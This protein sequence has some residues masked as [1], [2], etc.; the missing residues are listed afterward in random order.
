M[1]VVRLSALDTSRLYPPGNISG[2][3]FCLRLRRIQSHSAAGRIRSMKK[4]SDTIG[5]RTRNLP[6]FSALP[7][8]TAPPR[9]Q[10]NTARVEKERDFFCSVARVLPFYLAM[11]WNCFSTQGG[12]TERCRC[13]WLRGLR[14]GSAATRLPGLQVRIPPAVR[15]SVVSVVCCGRSLRRADHSSKGV[16]QTVAC[17]SVI[18]KSRKERSW[19][20]IGPK[21]HRKKNK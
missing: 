13:Q 2:T 12:I 21:C 18:V 15:M 19:P 1:K 8:W 20:G 9:A 3:Y 14:R 17:L 4:C 6:F 11:H 16:L 5:N 10:K 7:A